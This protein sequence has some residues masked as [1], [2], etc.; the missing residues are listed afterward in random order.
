MSDMKKKIA[1]LMAQHSLKRASECAP[2]D[3]P[4]MHETPPAKPD[5]AGHADESPDEELRRR[6][7]TLLDLSHRLNLRS[8][9][10]WAEEREALAARLEAGDFEI[11]RVMPGEL[12]GDED[13]RFFLVRRDYPLEHRQ[14]DLQLGDALQCLSS[15]VAFSAC[16]PALADFNPQT[17][18]FMDTETIG[19]AGGAGTVAFLVGVGYFH[20]DMFR[21]DQCFLRDYDDEEAM[22]HFLTERFKECG[23]V[24]GYNSKSFDLPLLR[25]RFIQHRIPFPLGEVPHYDLV[26][27]AR[28]FYK[29]RLADCSLGNIERAVLGIARHGDVPGY[30][31]PQMW[32]DYLRT[33]DARPLDRV[34]YH[35][36]MDILSLVS[37]TAWLSRCLAAPDGN[38]FAHVEDR[39][40]LVRLH[41]RQKQ[42]DQVVAHANA[43]LEK[44]ERSPLRREC[45]GLLATACKRTGRWAEMQQALELFVQEFPSDVFA[46]L[47]LAKHHEHRSR[48][49]LTAEALLA[50]TLA[51]AIPEEAPAIQARLD[52]VRNKLHRGRRFSRKRGSDVDADADGELPY[53]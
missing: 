22:L 29:R 24:V 2:E 48:D 51:M 10:E 7:R 52:R 43:F 45:L 11:D 21:L 36:R 33:R 53:A 30:L 26:H 37:L 12:I 34:F 17:A 23:S 6:R 25:T 8:G 1:D 39:I 5:D 14:G 31:I 28:R 32:F 35:H 44:E 4:P 47:E 16:D 41:F 13:S 46:R 15:H 19:L 3:A 9:G 20:D 27:A 50:E 38:G 40:S 18:L 42:Y 49:L